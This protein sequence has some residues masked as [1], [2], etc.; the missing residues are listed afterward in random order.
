MLITS[1][2]SPTVAAEDIAEL[3]EQATVRAKVSIIIDDL[4]YTYEQGEMLINLPYDVTLAIIPYTP[5]GQ[6]IAQ[7]ASQHAKEV[8]IH[9]PMETLNQTKWEDS[10]TTDMP[11]E[12][13][14]RR[15]NNMLEHIPEA[16]GINNHGGSKLTQNPTS[17]RWMMSA[18]GQKDLY[19]ID[20]RTTAASV[21]VQAAIEANIAH[22]SRDI[23]LD[24][25]R[26]NP[27]IFE[28]FAKLKQKALKNGK[29][30]GIGHPYPETMAVLKEV[31]PALKREGIRVVFSSDLVERPEE[32][33]ALSYVK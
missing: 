27:A 22:Q 21:A 13:L 3:Y 25:I 29:A 23:F 7:L 31:L 9:V 4:G 32:K 20:S 33:P 1:L 11:R 18:I 19:F 2:K 14:I 5:Y 8:M 12:V 24:N 6:E 10:L 30:I 28:Q 26:T 15:V 16:K 17:M